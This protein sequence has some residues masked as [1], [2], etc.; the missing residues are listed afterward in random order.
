MRSCFDHFATTLPRHYA[1]PYLRPMKRSR[2]DLATSII[3]E[4]SDYLLINKPPFI[5]TLEDRNDDVN[6]LKSVREQ[7]PDAQVGH[8]LDKDTSGILAV[9]LN[10]E[11]Y[12]NISM[13]LEHRE[14]S[15]VYHAVAEGN[16]NFKDEKVDAPILKQADGKVKISREGKMAETWFTSL[17]HFKGYTFVECRPVTGRMHQIRIHLASLKAPI[18]GDE[19]YGGHPVLLSALKRNYNLKRDTI[20]EPLI[21]RMA[22]HAFSL[23]FSGLDGK[24]L[25]GEAPYPKDFRVLLKQLAEN[26]R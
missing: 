14:A 20:E 15:K 22:L 11:A 9:A 13:Q 21:K 6:I 7:Y 2:F 10:P 23:E 12:R 19:Q 16:H 1:T 25:K 4:N 18:A 26:A 3:F 24:M 17:E 8:R 5:S